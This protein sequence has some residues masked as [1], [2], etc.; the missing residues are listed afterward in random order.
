MARGEGG[1]GAPYPAPSTVHGLQDSDTAVAD[2]VRLRRKRE[3]YRSRRKRQRAKRKACKLSQPEAPT[4][5][6]RG[7]HSDSPSGDDDDDDG[8]EEE[9]GREG[10]ADAL[11][12]LVEIGPLF[13]HPLSRGRSSDMKI[14]VYF[15]DV[16]DHIFGARDS[17]DEDG[18]SSAS[19]A[20]EDTVMGRNRS[21]TLSRTSECVYL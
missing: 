12:L 10:V 8:E 7:G 4:K 11:G 18:G 2:T 1:T 17:Q 9:Q 15:D 13:P 3:K 5:R 14:K 19:E 16:S 6:R 21:F 20:G